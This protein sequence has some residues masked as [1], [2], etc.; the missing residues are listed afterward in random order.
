ME[1]FSE[2]DAL[3]C[4]DIFPNFL[5]FLCRKTSQGDSPHLLKNNALTKYSG[6]PR[7]AT[8]YQIN[9]KSESTNGASDYLSLHSSCQKVVMGEKSYYCVYIRQNDINV[10]TSTDKE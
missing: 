2:N 5:V 4:T 9:V 6:S 1:A 8:N 3:C 7:I 10:S